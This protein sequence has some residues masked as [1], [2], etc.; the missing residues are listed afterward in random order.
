[1]NYYTLRSQNNNHYIYSGYHK[2]FLLSNSILNK[3]IESYR[4]GNEPEDIVEDNFETTDGQLGSKKYDISEIDYNINF[5]NYLRENN[6]FKTKTIKFEGQITPSVIKKEIANISRVVFEITSDCNLKCY[7][8]TYGELYED[9]DKRSNENISFEKAKRL[10]DYIFHAYNSNENISTCSKLEI[11]FY[12]GEPFMNMEGIKK[13]IKYVKENK[14]L[15][16]DVIYST[17]TNGTLL[18]KN[19]EFVVDN[20]FRIWI[21]IDGNLQNNKLRVYKNNKK[22]TF[23]KVHQN[24]MLLKNKYPQYFNDKVDFQAVLHSENSLL[25]I[26]DFIKT[27]YNKVPIISE[28]SKVGLKKCCKKHFTSIFK[29]KKKE[30]SDFT[31]GTIIEDLF[32]SLPNVKTLS[33]TI[34]KLTPFVVEYPELTKERKK[35]Y[36]PTGTCIPFSIEL[37][38]TVS[39]KILPC[40]HIGQQFTLANVTDEGVEIEYNRISEMYKRMFSNI[41]NLCTNCERKLI[42]TKCIFKLFDR[43]HKIDT[44]DD[45]MDFNKFTHFLED[46]ISVMENNP[47]FYSRISKELIKKNI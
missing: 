2:L 15:L 21:S 42:C 14:P 31:Q 37:F 20:D 6:F 1:M 26:Y 45:F 30:F 28:L 40:E 22:E 23:S 39:G 44:C 12:G 35:E 25:E 9:Y 38:M 10:L 8:C 43:D 3:I 19:M 27:N 41:K 13:I 36:L 5:F 29:D 32:T 33:E 11:N 46:Q 47:D 24:I 16:L 34:E 17:T 18:D 7:Y 4:Q